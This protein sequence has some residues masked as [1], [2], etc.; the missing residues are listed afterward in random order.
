MT[1]EPKH[2]IEIAKSRGEEFDVVVAT[3]G[4]GTVNEV[5]NGLY[6]LNTTFGIL[7]LGNGNDF[8]L[9]IKLDEDYNRSLDILE[10]GLTC[11]LTVGLAKA[12]DVVLFSYSSKSTTSI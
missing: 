3:G 7:P 5:A 8:A 2:A 11:D 10:E 12:E 6:G 4:D 1:D 9:G